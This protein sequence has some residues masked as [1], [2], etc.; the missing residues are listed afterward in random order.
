MSISKWLRTEGVFSGLDMLPD[1]YLT[2]SHNCESNR[3]FASASWYENYLLHIPEV[4]Q[5]VSFIALSSE[6]SRLVMP[7]IHKRNSARG[8]KYVS[9]EGLANYYSPYFE[10]MHDASES[11]VIPLMEE[12]FSTLLHSGTHWDLL[13]FSPLYKGGLVHMALVRVLQNAKASWQEFFC[14]N[15][16]YQGIT[17]SYGEYLKERPGRLRSTIKRRQRRLE[18]T[19]GSRV[20]IITGGERLEAG[21]QAYLEVYGRSWK[22]PESHRGFIIDLIRLAAANGWLR[23][24]VIWVAQKPIATQLWLVHADTAYIYKLAHDERY[25]ELSPGTLLTA[26]LMRRV[27]DEDQVKEV[28]FLTGDDAYKRDWMDGSRP[29]V[30]ILVFNRHTVRGLALAARHKL[31]RQLRRVIG[32]RQRRRLPEV[33]TDIPS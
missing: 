7:V 2:Q 31:G 21:I 23:L 20:E 13:K 14:F 4:D 5:I 17:G 9:V 33:L 1:G 11:A 8:F 28:D 18:R 32:N 25:R 10:P 6:G 26:V 30:G 24:G 27:I 15:N 19:A 29:M 16:W 22:D 3:L 12:A